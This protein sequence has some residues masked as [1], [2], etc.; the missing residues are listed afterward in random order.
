[1]RG[2]QGGFG[3]LLSW[4]SSLKIRIKIKI[5]VRIQIKRGTPKERIALRGDLDCQRAAVV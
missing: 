2:A 4:G 5:R 3:I 1:L